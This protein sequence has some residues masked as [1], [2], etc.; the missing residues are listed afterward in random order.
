MNF[1]E[2][3]LKSRTNWTILVMFL[4]NGVAGI[5]AFIPVG[6]LPLIDGLLGILA[7]YFRMN[8]KVDMNSD[9]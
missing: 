2:K 4:V 9:K 7:V 5:K 1:F 3:L 6:W 8:P